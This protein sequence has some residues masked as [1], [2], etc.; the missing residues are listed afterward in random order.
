MII[1]LVILC[2]IVMAIA[3]FYLLNKICDIDGVEH[4]YMGNILCLTPIIGTLTLLLTLF[5][6]TLL[7][8][9]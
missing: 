3:N 8:T 6:L 4:D 1:L 2:Y 7:K 9:K 5:I